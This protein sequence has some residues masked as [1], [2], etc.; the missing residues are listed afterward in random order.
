MITGGDAFSSLLFFLVITSVYTLIG[1]LKAEIYT[2]VMQVIFIVFCAIGFSVWV[3]Y[4]SSSTDLLLPAMSS[5]SN[6]RAEANTEYSGLGL[7]LGLP[8][9]GFWFWCADQSVVQKM[10]SI[11]SINFAKKTTA[12]SVLL[13][14]I[15]VVIFILPGI[16]LASFFQKVSVEESLHSLFSNGL[17]PDI[18]KGGLIIAV[19][20]TLMSNVSGLFNSTATLITFDFYRN[21]KPKS[22]DRKLVLIG[23]MTTIVL[24]FCSLLLLAV[25]PSMNF[26]F[27]IKLFKI[28]AYFSA[29]VTA[30]FLMGLINKKINA[31]SALSTLI[32]ATAIILLRSGLD[33]FYNYT[34]ENSLVNWFS[35]SGFLEFSIFIFTLCILLLFVFNK[36][37]L[38]RH[39]LISFPGFIRDF[40]V[41]I[42]I[43]GS[44][45]ERVLFILTALLIIIICWKLF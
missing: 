3:I 33:L 29:M 15:P 24:L 25:S 38:I 4:Q 39:I 17:L 27:C 21:L 36:L 40:L 19:A 35:N 43:K 5:F 7:L 42:K 12:F 9:V 22:S 32:A 10:L 45:K 44:L 1:G 2:N 11:R 14:I 6:V 28:T 34:N 8:I 13:Q 16:I 18:L 41:R 26:E 23:R 31:T 37:E 20:C 30:V